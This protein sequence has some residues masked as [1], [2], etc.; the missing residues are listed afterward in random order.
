MCKTC[1]VNYL[2]HKGKR[3]A[4]N[5]AY[6]EPGYSV[7]SDVWTLF[8][9]PNCDVRYLFFINKYGKVELRI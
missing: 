4:V 1:T 3:Y 2:K 8:N 7:S 9:F 5:F 6:T